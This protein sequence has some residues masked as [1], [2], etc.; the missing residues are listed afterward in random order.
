MGRPHAAVRRR[1]DRGLE[2][3]GE[4]A[5]VR[6]PVG[7]AWVLA[8]DEPALRAAAGPAAPARLLPSGDTY[9]LLHGAD[10]ALLVPEAGRRALLWTPRVWPG[11][12]LLGGEPAGT[13]R[14]SDATLRVHAWRP[15]LPAEREAV[16]A[17]AAA[18]P[19]PG[20]E[21]RIRV[22]WAGLS[23]GR[24]HDEGPGHVPGAF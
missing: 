18:L 8:A 11:A 15:L 14:R 1:R 22:E 3:A 21:G 24:R 12:L 10:R 4:L 20:A 16:E 6:T 23:G 7:D 19:L 13:W 9:Y 5:P 17:E 2:A